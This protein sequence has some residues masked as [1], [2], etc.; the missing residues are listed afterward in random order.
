MSEPPTQTTLDQQ[1]DQPATA[2]E[3][4]ETIRY[5]MWSVF[6]V[7]GRARRGPGRRWPSR[8]SSEL[9]RLAAKDLTVRGWYDVAGLRA[10][11]DLMVWWHAPELETVQQ[12]YRT[13]PAY[14][15]RA[16]R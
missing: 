10:D 9:D 11:A 1:V 12:A 15:A 2:R 14:G 3:I 16:G 7:P 5:A 4:N 6:A 13:L 8:S